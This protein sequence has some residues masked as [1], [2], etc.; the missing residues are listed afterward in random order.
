[1]AEPVGK[2]A[3][4]R[5]R[6]A[7]IDDLD[8]LLYLCAEHAR[9]EGCD[10]SADGKHAGLLR[11][12]STSPPRLWLWVA[13]VDEELVGYAAAS[14]EFSTWQACDFLHLDCLYVSAAQ[15]GAGIG[16]LLLQ[17]VARHAQ[18][19]GLQEIQWQTPAW[20]QD[21][22]RFYRRAGATGKSKLRFTWRP[23]SPNIDASASSI[24]G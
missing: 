23:G 20:N 2:N 9:Y 17:T 7:R 6:P 14:R 8:A 13:E 5:I 21:A 19:C 1:M 16:A 11:A 15:R 24:P 3:W 4:V 12:L 18:Q 10:Y 22:A